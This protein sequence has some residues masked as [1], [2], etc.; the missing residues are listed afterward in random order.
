MFE[1]KQEIILRGVVMDG[2]NQDKWFKIFD[3]LDEIFVRKGSIS[4][5]IDNCIIQNFNIDIK[6][7]LPNTTRRYFAEWLMEMIK[8][9]GIN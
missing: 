1:K 8:K 2:V 6:K 4:I 5:K 3:L 9:Q 7:T